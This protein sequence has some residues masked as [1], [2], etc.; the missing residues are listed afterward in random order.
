M[1]KK[2]K[3]FSAVKKVFSSSDPDEKEAKAEKADKSKSRRKWLF[4][5]SKH[6]DPSTSTMSGTAPVALL[7]PPPSTPP[8]QPHTQE[9]KD[10]K[11]VETDSEQN[12]HAYSVALASAVAAEAA[13]V[14][15]QAAAEV[16]RLTAVTT[17]SQKNAC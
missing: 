13:A 2:G 10:V 12:K 7:P 17:P 5:K 3:W 8:T 6:S 14:A 11:P 9:I 16:V 15:A 1:G 4:G